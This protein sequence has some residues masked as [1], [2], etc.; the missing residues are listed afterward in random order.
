MAILRL[1][2]RLTG[3]SLSIKKGGKSRPFFLIIWQQ[4]LP[5]APRGWWT[6]IRPCRNLLGVRHCGN[7]GG[8]RH[9]SEHPGHPCLMRSWK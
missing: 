2:T 6:S 8:L 9:R 4:N 7:P 3:S 5:V 1:P